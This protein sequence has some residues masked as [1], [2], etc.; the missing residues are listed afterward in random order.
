VPESKGNRTI[1]AYRCRQ[2]PYVW[3]PAE[4]LMSD[5]EAVDAT[6][7]EHGGR[8][9]LFANMIEN[10][11]G[12]SWDELFLFSAESPL[13]TRWKPHR[14]NPIVSDVARSRPAG[15]IF[16]RD[17]RLYR[18]SQNSSRCYGYALNLNEIT[19]LSDRNY[20]ERVVRTVE[21]NWDRRIYATHTYSSEHGLTLIDG[22]RRLW[23]RA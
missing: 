14:K 4:V 6:L 12:S 21:P 15:P 7:L 19:E 3:E 13:S 17:G 11:G 5:V 18:P 20:S 23:R 22:M 10:P 2:F 1:E 9:W 16:E 8:W